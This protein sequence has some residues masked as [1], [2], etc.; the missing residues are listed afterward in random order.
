MC[1]GG[2]AILDSLCRVGRS[3]RLQ[4]RTVPYRYAIVLE[5][6]AFATFTIK[7]FLCQTTTN[8]FL[9]E[10]KK[11]LFFLPNGSLRSHTSHGS[12]NLRA[13]NRNAFVPICDK[14][15]DI[16][17]M[18][19]S[20]L[21]SH[22]KSERHKNRAAM[23]NDNECIKSF[24]AQKPCGSPQ[25]LSTPKQDANNNELCI[26]ASPHPTLGALSYQCIN[27]LHCKGYCV[28]SRN[29]VN[30]ETYSITSVIQIFWKYWQIIRKCF[31]IA[32]L[33]KC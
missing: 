27:K 16:G 29:S 4:F 13:I 5:I 24:F 32:K 19:E 8:F 14:L 33:S 10:P 12:K 7:F 18:G 28:E 9:N 20:A 25:A 3:V 6:V 31:R 30:S 1:V 26:P 2:G 17:T 15:I 23:R 22:M 11:V 21:K